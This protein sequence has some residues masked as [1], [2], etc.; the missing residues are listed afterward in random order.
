VSSAR[1]K[2]LGKEVVVDVHF[3]ETSLPSVTLGKAFAE[4]ILGI[5]E[6]FRHSTKKLFPVLVNDDIRY[7]VYAKICCSL[8]L[9]GVGPF[10]CAEELQLSAKP[11]FV[12]FLSVKSFDYLVF[13]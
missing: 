4:C 6:C 2:V 3:T 10:K 5:A 13:S 11:N 12:F 8:I 9:F 1:Q 7:V